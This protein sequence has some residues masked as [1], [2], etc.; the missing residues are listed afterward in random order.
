MYACGIKREREQQQQQKYCTTN[1]LSY[2]Y[3]QLSISD[4]L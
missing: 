4:L 1:L 2:N 3:M